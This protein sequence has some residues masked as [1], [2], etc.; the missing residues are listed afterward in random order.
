MRSLA[1][2]TCDFAVVRAL[3]DAGHDVVAVVELR[4]RAEDD[5]VM[6]VAVRQQ[7]I[8]LT[9]DKDFGRLVFASQ[10]TA[11]GVVLIRFPASQRR[12]LP[13]AFLDMVR[14]VGDRLAGRF[15]VLQPRR[16]RISQ[17]PKE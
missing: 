9:E 13:S 16:V 11:L 5:A 12:Y 14:Q 15:A 6:D 7:R 17:P 4:P 3:R 10:R 1:D 8:L 2:E